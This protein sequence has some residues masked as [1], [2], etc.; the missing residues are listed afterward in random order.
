MFNLFLMTMMTSAADSIN[1]IAISQ[2]FVLQGMVKRK[3]D[4]WYYIIAIGFTNFLGGL[5]A[6]YGLISAISEFFKGIIKRFGTG[7]YLIEIG[8]GIILLISTVVIIYKNYRNKKMKEDEMDI[9]ENQISRKI[10]SVSPISLTALGIVAT[11]SELT[12]ALPYFAFLA[13]LFKYKLSLI[14]ILTILIVYNIIY[15]MPLILMY[16]VYIKAQNKFDK[17][18][19]IIKAK[20]NKWSKVLAPAITMLIGLLLIYHP[21]TVM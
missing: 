9:E 5:L 13:I 17:V 6:Y 12:T 4:I 10:K 18:Y 16:F 11:I 15:S 21:I 14:V 20:M 19:S 2:Q 7:I 1:P 8:I 3:N